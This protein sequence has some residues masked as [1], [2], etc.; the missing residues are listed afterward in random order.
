MKNMEIQNRMTST[1]LFKSKDRKGSIAPVNSPQN[2]LHLEVNMKQLPRRSL[3]SLVALALCSRG[4]CFRASSCRSPGRSTRR[5]VSHRTQ[6]RPGEAEGD[7][8]DASAKRTKATGVYARPSAAIERGSGFFVPGLEGPKVRLVFGIILL[9][10]TFVNHILPNQSSAGN[11]L[12]EGLAGFYSLFVLLQAAIEFT[13][14]EK[15]KIVVGGQGGDV[16]AENVASYKQQWS[17]CAMDDTAWRDKVQWAASSYLSLT[18]ATHI[19]LLGPG[20][21][22]FS[23]GQSYPPNDGDKVSTGTIAALE[24]LSKS[25]SGRVSLPSSHPTVKNVADAEFRRCVV[26]QRVDEA[27]QLC[28]MMTSNELLPAFTQQELEWLGRLASYVKPN[29]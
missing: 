5:T 15:G 2:R 17:G 22:I 10:S 16:V 14:E 27:S 7:V 24:A 25:Q 8:D 6:A 29:L 19:M 21:V 12:S 20:K 13:K 3:I 28:W 11:T 4:H 9:S 18:R 1:S 23:L 26:L